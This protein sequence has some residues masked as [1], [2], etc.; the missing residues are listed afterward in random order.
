MP[1]PYKGDAISID[2]GLIKLPYDKSLLPNLA[3]GIIEADNPMRRVKWIKC[4]HLLTWILQKVAGLLGNELRIESL[5]LLNAISDYRIVVFEESA[6]VFIPCNDTAT[7]LLRL[8]T[9]N[10]ADDVESYGMEKEYFSNEDLWMLWGAG[11]EIHY[12]DAVL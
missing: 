1:T 2:A 11:Y 10:C 6:G 3:H 7:N 8:L 12:K 4:S 5:S 9:I